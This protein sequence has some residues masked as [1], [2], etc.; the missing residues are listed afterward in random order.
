MIY[1]HSKVFKHTAKAVGI[2]KANGVGNALDGRAGSG[3]HLRPSSSRKRSEG[4]GLLLRTLLEAAR[5]S[6]GRDSYTATPQKVFIEVARPSQIRKTA[7]SSNLKL[8]RRNPLARRTI[9]TTSSRATASTTCG[10]SLLRS[11][12]RERLSAVTPAE[13]LNPLRHWHQ[14]FTPE[15][16]LASSAANLQW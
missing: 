14:F 9:Y 1:R 5:H 8:R 6:T 11:R 16:R 10:R 13:I 4:S 15:K 3:N 2:V 7:R 12:A